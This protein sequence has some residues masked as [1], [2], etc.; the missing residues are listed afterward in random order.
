MQILRT[1]MWVLVLVALLIFSI[2][3]W[4]PVE[5]KIWE[6]L[7]L[8]TKIPALVIVAFLAGLI[9]M[10]LIYRGTKWRLKRRISHLEQAAIT[11]PPPAQ[12]APSAQTVQPQSVD[13]ASDPVVAP[14]HTPD[15]TGPSRI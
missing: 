5:V 9:P 6:G 7:V 13:P 1:I 4:D 3:N 11:P 8:E 10:W 2:F 15:E 14:E 12:P